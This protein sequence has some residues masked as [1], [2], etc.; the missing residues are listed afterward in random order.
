MVGDF[1][2]YI[3]KLFICLRESVSNIAFPHH[4]Q[5]NIH[6]V[7][8]SR[9]CVMMEK[10]VKL[11]GPR[12]KVSTLTIKDVEDVEIKTHCAFISGLLVS[13]GIVPN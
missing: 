13:T 9:R 12:K 1:I 8:L 10:L 6:D 11:K 5:Y 3:F 2:R 4:I 7:M